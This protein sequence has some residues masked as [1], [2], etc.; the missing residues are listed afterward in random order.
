MDIKLTQEEINEL[1]RFSNTTQSIIQDLGKLELQ[2]QDL[3]EI[4]AQVLGV[5][6]TMKIEQRT[7]FEKL[8]GQHGPGEIDYQ[9]LTYKVG[10]TSWLHVEDENVEDE[11]QV[12]NEQIKSSHLTVV[13]NEDEPIP[14]PEKNNFG[15]TA[16]LKLV[17]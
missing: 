12:V 14:V 3:Q 7:F 2:M 11:N 16:D 1:A 17:E 10:A 6:T 9:N 8:H 13:K 4:K 5:M 15:T